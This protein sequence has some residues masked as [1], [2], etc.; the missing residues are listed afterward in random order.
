M[1]I[2]QMP[3]I[4]FWVNTQKKIVRKRDGTLRSQKMPLASS[5]FA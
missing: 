2:R 1:K 3:A 5:L 4:F